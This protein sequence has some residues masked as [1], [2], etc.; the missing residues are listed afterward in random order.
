MP[1]IIRSGAT[2]M[3]VPPWRNPQAISNIEKMIPATMPPITPCRI[4][5]P[6]PRAGARVSTVTVLPPFLSGARVPEARWADGDADHILALAAPADMYLSGRLGDRQPGRNP[7]PG[8]VRKRIDDR[9][10]R[11]SKND[12]AHQTSP[13]SFG[14]VCL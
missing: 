5:P 13:M 3:S 10:R 14:W 7:A 9:V 4:H 2:A 6:Q 12:V 11:G 8:S 1:P